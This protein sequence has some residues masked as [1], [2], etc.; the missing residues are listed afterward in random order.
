MKNKKSF[1]IKRSVKM[2]EIAS[3]NPL[4]QKTL[5]KIIGGRTNNVAGLY[6]RLAGI[7]EA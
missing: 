2:N 7:Q 5:Q 6:G 1:R 4:L 3:K